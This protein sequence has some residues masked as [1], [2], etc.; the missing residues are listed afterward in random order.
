MQCHHRLRLDLLHIPRSGPDT[1]ALHHRN[2]EGQTDVYL[3]HRQ[4]VPNRVQSVHKTIIKI[5]AECLK[6]RRGMV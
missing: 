3:H 5:V 4:G 1:V 2:G 6:K